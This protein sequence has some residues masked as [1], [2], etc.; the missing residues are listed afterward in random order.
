MIC[1]S[2]LFDCPAVAL[3]PRL[4]SSFTRVVMLSLDE[5]SL[6]FTDIQVSVSAHC[7]RPL[8]LGGEAAISG[9]QEMAAIQKK[10][11]PRKT[12]RREE[13]SGRAGRGGEVQGESAKGKA[14]SVS[15]VP[16]VP[17]VPFDDTA[18]R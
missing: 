16:K 8:Y 2:V 13:G 11:N 1:V 17:V 3:G 9:L 7:N 14:D 12:G 6:A 18:P 5:T 4:G 10:S 15:C